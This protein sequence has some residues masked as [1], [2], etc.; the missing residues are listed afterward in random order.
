MGKKTELFYRH[1]VIRGAKKFLELVNELP[2]VENVGVFNT[3]DKSIG[4]RN[5]EVRIKGYDMQRG[6]LKTTFYSVKDGFQDFMIKI[7]P[8]DFRN[9]IRVVESEGY[10]LSGKET[11]GLESK[12]N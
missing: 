5:P 9:F 3:I 1:K 7:N 6:Q 4:I 11:I 10:I 8:Q 12:T 2:Y